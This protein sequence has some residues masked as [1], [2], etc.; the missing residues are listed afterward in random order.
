MMEVLSNRGN[1]TYSYIST[2]EAIQDFQQS[3]AQGLLR[4]T[5]RDAR[6]QVEFNENVVEQYRLI[7]YENRAVADDD[8]RDDTLDFGEPAFNRDITAL[9]E[10]KLTPN[11]DSGDLVATATVRWRNQGQDRHTETSA[12]ITAGELDQPRES[13]SAHLLRTM[14]VAELAEIMRAS[15]WAQCAEPGSPATTAAAKIDQ[16]TG[17]ARAAALVIQTLEQHPER[18]RCQR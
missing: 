1:G 17:P 6:A 9:Y 7:G 5:V 14:A 10:V 4:D 2:Q 8:F 3:T 13:A 12:R 11:A 16:D 18:L 15:F